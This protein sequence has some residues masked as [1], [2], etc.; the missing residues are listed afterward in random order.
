MDFFVRC[1][2]YGDLGKKYSKK[3]RFEVYYNKTKQNCGIAWQLNYHRF[4]V[5]VFK[6]LFSP[7]KIFI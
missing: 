4:L 5:L 7:H 6:T 1:Q 3:L 2:N